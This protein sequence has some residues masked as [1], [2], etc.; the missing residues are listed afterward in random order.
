[1]ENRWISEKRND[2]KSG[3]N[4][5]CGKMNKGESKTESDEITGRRNYEKE[6]ERKDGEERRGKGARRK[7]RK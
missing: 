1:M 4:G 2:T 5:K 3:Q 7:E 6:R